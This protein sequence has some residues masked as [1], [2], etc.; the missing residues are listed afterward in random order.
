MNL[1]SKSKSDNCGDLTGTWTGTYS[2]S[3]VAPGCGRFHCSTQLIFEDA[4][5]DGSAFFVDRP[6]AIN[7]YNDNPNC[8]TGDLGATNYFALCENSKVEME[9]F[10]GLVSSSRLRLVKDN[11][12]EYDMHND[13]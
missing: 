7:C 1:T 13:K 4:S 3:S 10:E 11:D 12:D 2:Y 8:S 9:G 5:D 6:K